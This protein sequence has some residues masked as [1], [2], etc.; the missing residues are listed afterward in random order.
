MTT[1]T[2]R[3]ILWGTA[4]ALITQTLSVTGTGG[5]PATGQARRANASSRGRHIGPA[6]L[7]SVR[8]ADQRPQRFAFAAPELGGLAH[9]VHGLRELMRMAGAKVFALLQQHHP[10]GRPGPGQVL[11]AVSERVPVAAERGGKPH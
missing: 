9:D 4:G 8:T 11:E 1:S 2:E 10:A 5:S 6:R 7:P 3:G